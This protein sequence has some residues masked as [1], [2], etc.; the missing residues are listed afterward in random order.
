MKDRTCQLAN[1]NQDSILKAL[2]DKTGLPVLVLDNDCLDSLFYSESEVNGK[3]D[4]FTEILS[5]QA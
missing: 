1:T 4:A 2:A 5:K 3:I